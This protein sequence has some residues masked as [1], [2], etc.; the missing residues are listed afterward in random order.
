MAGSHLINTPAVQTPEGVRLSVHCQ[1]GA[2]RSEISG[3]HGGM[4]KVKVSAP[5]VEGKANKALLELLAA[6]LGTT[7]R[8][9]RITSGEQGRVKSVL[10]ADVTVAEVNAR[11]GLL[12][13]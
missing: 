8:R 6:Q 12:G 5:A 11:L 10:I 7:P 2:S 4:L 1:P 3:I 13:I 9:L